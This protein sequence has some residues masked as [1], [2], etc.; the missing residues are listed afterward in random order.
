MQSACAN[1]S[2][3]APSDGSC[4]RELIVPIVFDLVT[5]E[6]VRELASGVGL[7]IGTVLGDYQSAPFEA[8]SSPFIIVEMHA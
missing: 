5:L 7:R 4:T 2:A 6:E 1:T 3:N 8:V